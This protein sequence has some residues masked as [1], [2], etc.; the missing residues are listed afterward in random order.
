MWAKS[1][2]AAFALVGFLFLAACSNPKLVEE[3]VAFL[4]SR[5]DELEVTEEDILERATSMNE[6]E[7]VVTAMEKRQASRLENIAAR[8]GRAQ[9]RILQL[10]SELFEKEEKMRLMEKKAENYPKTLEAKEKALDARLQKLLAELEHIS[11]K[12]RPG[13]EKVVLIERL[14]E[15][16]KAL[17]TE[18]ETLRKQLKK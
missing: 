8:V 7:L 17:R 14:L 1:A 10:E 5:I 6:L 12:P 13:E 11:L 4:N 16:V 9:K 18:N 3:Q 2:T 15:E